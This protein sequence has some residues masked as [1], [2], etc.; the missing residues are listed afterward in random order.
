VFA[1]FRLIKHRTSAGALTG[2]KLHLLFLFIVRFEGS[3]SGATGDSSPQGSDVSLGWSR[4]Y[5]SKRRKPITQ[6]R[7]ATTPEN[8]YLS[9]FCNFELTTLHHANILGRTPK[10]DTIKSLFHS[11]PTRSAHT[12]CFVIWLEYTAVLVYKAELSVWVSAHQRC[13]LIMLKKLFRKA[14]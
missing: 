9:L 14:L 2:P 5:L 6:G 11:R 4:H 10:S 7:S 13:V 3:H 1:D 8:S 12:K